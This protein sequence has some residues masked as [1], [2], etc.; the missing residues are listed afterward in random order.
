M[1]FFLPRPS[2]S[3]S[4]N[5]QYIHWGFSYWKVQLPSPQFNYHFARRCSNSARD[6]NDSWVVNMS[7]ERVRKW[8]SLPFFKDDCSSLPVTAPTHKIASM[9]PAA[10]AAAR[11]LVQS[12]RRVLRMERVNQLSAIR[13]G[14][15]VGP[16]GLNTL[17]PHSRRRRKGNVLSQ[18]CTSLSCV[19]QSLLQEVPLH[20]KCNAV[21]L[22]GNKSSPDG[23]QV[24]DE[25]ERRQR[26]EAQFGA[27]LLFGANWRS[28]WSGSRKTLI[29]QSQ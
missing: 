21:M 5:C 1:L 10:A 15:K 12:G 22:I 3:R 19:C 29:M 2:L 14:K 7:T 18:W 20:P 8:R 28:N 25:E 17:S 27:L 13:D 4:L 16:I 9:A 26:W 6:N 11:T 24:S 23:W